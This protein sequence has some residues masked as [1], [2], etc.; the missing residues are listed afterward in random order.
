MNWVSVRVAGLLAGPLHN[1]LE[2]FPVLGE[3]NG[4]VEACL[5]CLP[6]ILSWLGTGI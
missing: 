3:W 5:A 2:I 1:L 4:A 6:P